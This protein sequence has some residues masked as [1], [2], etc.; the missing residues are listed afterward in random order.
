MALASGSCNQSAW[1]PTI[2]S[3][4]S[5][6]IVLFGAYHYKYASGREGDWFHLGLVANKAGLSDYVCATAL[7]DPG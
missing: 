3:S 6:G 1:L 4:I 5:N 7:C 2:Q